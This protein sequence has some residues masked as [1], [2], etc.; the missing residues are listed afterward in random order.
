MFLSIFAVFIVHSLRGLK[1][2]G[3]AD[4]Q[5]VGALLFLYCILYWVCR[6]TRIM[7]TSHHS[8]VHKSLLHNSQLP[9]PQ[10]STL[11][12]TSL[13]SLVHKSPLPCLQVSS[14]LSTSLCSVVH[15]SPISCPQ[16]SSLLS[17]S[18]CSLFHKP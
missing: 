13:C 6:P 1:G 2:R 17:T 18:L 10:V 16:V 4:W 11:L 8:F 14:L 9:C 15:K 12:F 3:I 5:H 7:S